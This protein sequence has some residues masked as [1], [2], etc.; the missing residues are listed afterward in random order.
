[1]PGGEDRGGAKGGPDTCSV[2][3]QAASQKAV[4]SP[5]WRP[6]DDQKDVLVQVRC[7]QSQTR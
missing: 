3:L 5:R 2:D 7:M 1:M 4:G 6:Q